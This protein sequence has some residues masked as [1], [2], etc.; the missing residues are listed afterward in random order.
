MRLKIEKERFKAQTATELISQIA[1]M[2]WGKA[3]TAEEYIENQRK[4]YKA[5]T[6]REMILPDGT[7]EE[8]AVAMFKAIS[9]I[10]GWDFSETD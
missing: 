3:D 9:E 4:S 6:G 2:H 10:G 1:W 5:V 8:R 7:T